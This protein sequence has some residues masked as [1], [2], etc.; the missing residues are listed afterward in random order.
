MIKTKR[1]F[2]HWINGDVYIGDWRDGV[3]HGHGEFNYGSPGNNYF[4]IC[5][6]LIL[7]MQIKLVKDILVNMKRVS[8][9]V[10]EP[11]TIQMEGHLLEH[12]KMITEKALGS[13]TILLDS[14]E[15]EDGFKISSW[16]KSESIWIMRPF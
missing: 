13:C 9:Q 6:K 8:E 1:I 3:P 12:F 16:G 10:M 2:F 15:K 7:S 5:I 4:F 14:G 11:T